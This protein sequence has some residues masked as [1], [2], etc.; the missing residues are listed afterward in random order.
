MEVKLDTGILLREG[1][2]I[3]LI[4]DLPISYQIKRGIEGGSGEISYFLIFQIRGPIHGYM[5]IIDKICCVVCAVCAW[6]ICSG[7]SDQI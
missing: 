4:S 5:C 3:E 7:V 6:Y 2:E 1:E